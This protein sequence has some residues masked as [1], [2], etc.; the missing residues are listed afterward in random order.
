MIS[1]IAVNY[2]FTV[3]VAM[4]GIVGLVFL[5]LVPLTEPDWGVMI[6]MGRQQGVLSNPLAA[7]MM[8]SPVVAIALFQLSL[9]M[10]ARSLEEVFNPRLRSSL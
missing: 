8:L 6:F 10:F 1:Y 4:Y 2:I 7:G 5:G 3:R 9:V